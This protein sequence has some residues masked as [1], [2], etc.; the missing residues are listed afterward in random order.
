MQYENFV[1]MSL[2]VVLKPIFSPN[3]PSSQ[4]AKL[5]RFAS[6]NSDSCNNSSAVLSNCQHSSAMI[7]NTSTL[8]NSWRDVHSLLTTSEVLNILLQVSGW[9]FV[10]EPS[11]ANIFYFTFFYSLSHIENF[12]SQFQTCLNSQMLP[13]SI[14]FKCLQ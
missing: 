14:Q 12:F 7:L 2:L 6:Y 8:F 5:L 10:Q 11:V 9:G 13:L 1:L 3:L 4:C